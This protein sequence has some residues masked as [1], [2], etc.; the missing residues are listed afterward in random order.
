MRL[1][2][3]LPLFILMLTGAAGSTA[4]TTGPTATTAGELIVIHAGTLLDRPGR[5]PR[6]NA[7]ILVRGGRIEAVQDGLLLFGLDDWLPS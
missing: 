4:Q 1:L 5:A 3:I 7:T 2:K 6:R